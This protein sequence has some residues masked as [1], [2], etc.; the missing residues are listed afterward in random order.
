MAAVLAERVLWALHVETVRAAH[1]RLCNQ[2]LLI[3]FEQNFVK[4]WGVHEQKFERK[5]RW[6]LNK[7]LIEGKVTPPQELLCLGVRRG[8]APVVLFEKI[9][10]IKRANFSIKRPKA[11][12]YVLRLLVLRS[13]Q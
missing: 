4:S 1:C 8:S 9:I 2:N 10:F 7:S 12:F 11:S 5:V 3:N 13:R 6:L